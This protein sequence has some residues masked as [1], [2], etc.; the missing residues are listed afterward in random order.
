MQMSSWNPKII[1][2]CGLV[3]LGLSSGVAFSLHNVYVSRGLMRSSSPV[4]GNPAAGNVAIADQIAVITADAFSR[5]S[6]SEIIQRP[7]L[8]LYTEARAHEP[9][10][11]II[12]RMKQKDIKISVIAPSNTFFVSFAY[13][14]PVKAQRTTQALITKLAD[15]NFVAARRD[16]SRAMSLDLLNPASL[17][18]DP[19]APNRG[20]I[21]LLGLV[22]GLI[23][24]VTAVALRRRMKR[25]QG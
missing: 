17:P 10:E 4:T 21:A 15:A 1:L 13:P 25:Q 16:P 20:Q 19:T 5:G 23:A 2:L 14:D 22:A 24:G 9:L 7:S 8:N 18:H 12:E 11:D 3:G 6:L